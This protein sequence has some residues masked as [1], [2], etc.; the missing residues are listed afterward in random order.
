MLKKDIEHP[1]LRVETAELAPVVQR[2]ISMVFV[3]LYIFAFVFCFLVS[4][5]VLRQIASISTHVPISSQV[6]FIGL[7]ILRTLCIRTLIDGN[8][9]FTLFTVSE[10]RRW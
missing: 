2:S 3:A 6:T 5:G 7:R 8:L 4:A 9:T 1:Q 10:F